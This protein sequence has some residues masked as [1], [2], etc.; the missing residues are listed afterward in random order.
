MAST[1]SQPS[2]KPAQP[3]TGQRIT[4]EEIGHAVLRASPWD[5]LDSAIETQAWID[6]IAVPLQNIS[7]TALKPGP[8]GTLLRN[9]LNGSFLGHPLHAAVTDGPIGSWTATL[10]LDLAS[11]RRGDRKL[12]KAAD[13]TLGVGLVGSVA[14]AIT[15]LADWSC[16]QSPLRGWGS[17]TRSPMQQWPRCTYP[18]YWRAEAGIGDSGAGFRTPDTAC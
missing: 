9:V 10:V 8:V 15:G 12:D 2:S 18:R 13:I 14:S 4:S 17:Y 3:P 6:K 11:S 7:S 1:T 16:I 5:K